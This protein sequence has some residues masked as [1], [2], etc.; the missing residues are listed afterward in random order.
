MKN[1]IAKI[2]TIEITLNVLTEENAV[3][4]LYHEMWK[5]FKK[6]MIAENEAGIV[7]QMER[8]EMEVRSR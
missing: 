6:K 7:I 3:N 1:T 4:Y 8:T 2:G 5:A